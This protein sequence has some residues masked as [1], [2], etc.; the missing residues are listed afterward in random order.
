MQK[1]H[2]QCGENKETGKKLKEKEDEL[3]KLLAREEIPYN[4]KR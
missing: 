1:E 2:K 4:K 3:R